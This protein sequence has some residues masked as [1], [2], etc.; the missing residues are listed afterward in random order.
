MREFLS[1]SPNV[2]G[3]FNLPRLFQLPATVPIRI[4]I[5]NVPPPSAYWKRRL[6]P[7]P[8]GD[9]YGVRKTQVL[10]NPLLPL[11]EAESSDLRVFSSGRRVAAHESSAEP[12][13]KGKRLPWPWGRSSTRDRP[14]GRSDVCKWFLLN[15]SSAFQCVS[16]SFCLSE[17]NERLGRPRGCGCLRG[18][19]A[20]RN[21][22]CSRSIRNLLRCPLCPRVTNRRPVSRRCS[23]PC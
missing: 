11:L 17:W 15:S 7:A 5:S 18:S 12:S 16:G 20:D 3:A 2:I 19:A 8:P 22:L 1:L 4:A 9:H 13:P 14:P 10:G 21:P 6:V 23:N